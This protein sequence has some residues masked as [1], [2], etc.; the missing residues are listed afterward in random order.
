M[1]Q[2]TQKLNCSVRMSTNQRQWFYYAMQKLGFSS[3]NSYL[4]FCGLEKA[5]TIHKENIN[6]SKERAIKQNEILSE[7]RGS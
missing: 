5:R 7:P 6:H 3:I 4:L 2:Q 1:E